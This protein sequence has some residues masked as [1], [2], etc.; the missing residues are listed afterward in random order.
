M[1]KEKE[2]NVGAVP[3]EL[4]TCRLNVLVWGTRGNDNSM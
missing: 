2:A 4:G 1:G 3:G